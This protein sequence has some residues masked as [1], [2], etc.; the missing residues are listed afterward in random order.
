M[1]DVKVKVYTPGGQ[2]VGYF[3]NPSINQFP[4]A[5]YEISG[6]F[7]EDTGVAI[8]KL[9]FNPQSVPYMADLS[10]VV[11]CAHGRL[12]NVYIQRG[13]QPVRMTGLGFNN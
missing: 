3:L 13:R 5:E 6:R 1:S 12:V 8:G 11:G 7:F 10:E 9:D 2:Y 4:E